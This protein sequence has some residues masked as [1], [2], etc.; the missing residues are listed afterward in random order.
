MQFNS[1]NMSTFQGLWENWIICS[2]FQLYEHTTLLNTV[3][4]QNKCTSK[5]ITL[6]HCK[7]LDHTGEYSP[8]GCQSAFSHFTSCRIIKLEDL[9]GHF[10]NT[11]WKNWKRETR[12]DFWVGN[13]VWCAVAES[14][15][16]GKPQK[17]GCGSKMKAW[18]WGS[19][20]LIF[21]EHSHQGIKD[22]I[23]ICHQVTHFPAS[24]SF[25][26]C[27]NKLPQT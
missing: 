20:N 7:L 25:Y 6:M 10:T 23:C 17:V 18:C 13:N 21:L 12:R 4:V 9:K 1:S 8:R 11:N 22:T 2:Q 15:Y 14:M 3:P 26:C 24:P 19:G 5:V 27:S 16:L